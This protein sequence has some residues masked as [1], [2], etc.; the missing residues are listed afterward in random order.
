MKDLGLPALPESL[1][2]NPALGCVLTIVSHIGSKPVS[3]TAVLVSAAG[4]FSLS[5]S[6]LSCFRNRCRRGAC[7]GP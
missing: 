4:T 1:M 6:F 2:R 5:G 7:L 3:E